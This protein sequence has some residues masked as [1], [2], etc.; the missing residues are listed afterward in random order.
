MRLFDLVEEDDAV[1]LSPH[2]LGQLTALVIADVSRRRADQTRDGELLHILTHVDAHDV[3][4][5]VKKAGGQ[6]LCQLR[7]AHACGAEEEERADGAVRVGDAGARAQDRLGDLLDG[8][9]L[10]DDPLM[11]RLVQVQQLFPLA[12]HEL[13]H[14]DARPLGHD[15]GDL[16]L[17]HGVAQHRGRLAL[18]GELFGL[19]KLPLQRGQVGVFQPRGRL[20]F[21]A[22][23]GAF[24][25]GVHLF[26]LALEALDVVDAVFL[27][28]PAG[29]HL[30][31]AV[32]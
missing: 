32:L 16:L 26:D 2:G 10:A 30:V 8:L 23:L 31:E 25:L 6:R 12:F 19:F 20:V 1:R 17:G 21:I 3:V 14:R 22:A 5:V 4:L 27:A 9:I 15:R 18:L 24:D 7:L 13:C 11:Q 29:F 28:L